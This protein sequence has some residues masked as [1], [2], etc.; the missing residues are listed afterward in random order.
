MDTLLTADGTGKFIVKYEM[1]DGYNCYAAVNKDNTYIGYSEYDIQFITSAGF[2]LVET[3]SDCSDIKKLIL[4]GDNY[5]EVHDPRTRFANV[6]LYESEYEAEEVMVEWDDDELHVT[7]KTASDDRPKYRILR[8]NVEPEDFYSKTEYGYQQSGSGR[9]TIEDNIYSLAYDDMYFYVNYA[10]ADL[11]AGNLLTEELIIHQ[12]GFDAVT[13]QDVVQFG[14]GA[15]VLSGEISVSSDAEIVFLPGSHPELAEDFYLTV[16]GLFTATG[17][18]ENHIIFDK[19]Q[20]NNWYKIEVTDTGIADLAYCEFQ[21]AQFPLNSKG[22]IF[23]DNCEFLFNDRGIYLEKP[24]RYQITNTYIHDNYQFGVFLRDSHETPY[25]S[26]IKKSKFTGNNYGL[27]FYNASAAVESDTIYA[28]KYAGILANRGSNPVVTYTTISYTHYD[29]TDYPEIRT[30]GTSY[31]V[32]DK[33]FNDIIFGNSYSIYNQDATTLEYYCRDQWWG[34]ILENEIENSFYPSNWLVNFLP[35]ATTPWVNHDPLAGDG[36]FSAGFI[37][38]S[39]GDYEWAKTAYMASIAENPTSLEAIWSANRLA[40]CSETEEELIELQ[41]YFDELLSDYPETELAL[42]AQMEK[43]FCY[44]LLGNYQEAITE[45]EELLDDEL[46]FIDSVYTQ[47]DIVYTYLDASAGGNRAAFLNFQ[48]SQNELLSIE[49]AEE[50][51]TE[52]WELLDEYRANGGTYSPEI[53]E[54]SLNKNYPNPFNPSTTISFSIP[55][56]S[57]VQISIYNLKGQKIRNLVSQNYQRG[58]YNVEWDGNNTSGNQ[59]GSGVYLYELRVN[60]RSE[61]VRKCLMLK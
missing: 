44:R 41:M 11:V 33:R 40:N 56:D 60:G 2:F 15:I 22:E 50:R 61:A 7:H 52:L 23:V 39:E 30:S 21:N 5:L 24:Q 32:V 51:K 43:I 14:R 6:V 37:A 47:L 45:Y 59:A 13:I 19:Y 46:S 57:E 1:P 34:T 31:P 38:E 36:L 18:E 3:N 53:S 17:T 54:I 9:G 4:N 35:I 28:N 29:A 49:Q 58:I 8:C 25:R 27:W 16:D 10:Y 26:E 55:E 20:A 12:G 42:T 48:N